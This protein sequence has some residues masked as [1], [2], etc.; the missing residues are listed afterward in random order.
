MIHGSILCIPRSEAVR[1]AGDYLSEMGLH[2]TRKAAPDITHLLL[3]VPSFPSGDEYLAHIL[4]DLPENIII[5]GGNLSSLLLKEYATV[6]FLQD[7]YYLAENAAITAGCALEIAESKLGTLPAGCKVLIVGWGRIGKC[8][9]R[10]LE[11]KGAA[12]TAAARK[13]TDRAMIRALGCRGIS[14][15]DAAQELRRYDVIMN[16]VPVMVLPDMDAKEDAVI[17]ELASKPGM[18]GNN[19][20]DARGLP[21]KMA[22]EASGKL[23][24]KTFVRLCLGKEV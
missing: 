18:C 23:I 11:K 9:C 3:P 19:I 10:I 13:D 2:V 5:S 17:L 22:P 6:D 20:I 21:G 4:R 24:A 12:V 15:G 8:L 16:T 1:R 14:I 7:P